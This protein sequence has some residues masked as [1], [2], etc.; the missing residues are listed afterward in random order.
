[1]QSANIKGNISVSAP[2]NLPKGTK[3]SEVFNQITCTKMVMTDEGPAYNNITLYAFHGQDNI[4]FEQ[5]KVYTIFYTHITIPKG[6]I[7]INRTTKKPTPFV[8]SFSG[9]VAIMAYPEKGNHPSI[10]DRLTVDKSLLPISENGVTYEF[11]H[12]DS[13]ARRIYLFN[14]PIEFMSYHKRFVPIESKRGDMLKKSPVGEISEQIFKNGLCPTLFTHP[15]DVSSNFELFCYELSDPKLTVYLIP[16]VD[17]YGQTL[18]YQFDDSKDTDI[19][20]DND[21]DTDDNIIILNLEKQNLKYE[22]AG[23]G[24][25]GP[26]MIFREERGK[27]TDPIN[28]GKAEKTKYLATFFINIVKVKK[29]SDVDPN[30]QAGTYDRDV[31]EEIKRFNPIDGIEVPL[32]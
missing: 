28:A 8:E 4:S 7:Y 26:I 19:D 30:V 11:L 24:A 18:F 2:P 29:K 21:I 25:A 20:T 9:L 23:V 5:G 15:L 6:F 16:L 22:H 31:Y 10:V 32:D 12:V 3:I 1:M 27:E 17:P 13:N 14:S